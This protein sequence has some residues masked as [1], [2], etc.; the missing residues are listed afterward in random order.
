MTDK[1]GTLTKRVQARLAAYDIVRRH[2]LES[3][4]SQG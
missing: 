4:G 1:P 2:D 3:E